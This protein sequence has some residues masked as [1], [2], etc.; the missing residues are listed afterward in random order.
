[1]S[2]IAYDWF[3]DWHALN[4]PRPKK[5]F[6]VHETGTKG[7]QLSDNIY[8]DQDGAVEANMTCYRWT[9]GCLWAP[10]AREFTTP[11]WALRRRFITWRE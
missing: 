10:M 7:V 3:N 6:L 8:P 9:E 1:M 2:S 4:D 11:R 5:C